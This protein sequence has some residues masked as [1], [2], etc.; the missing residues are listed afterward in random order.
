M[1]KGLID[2]IE[3]CFVHFHGFLF[4]KLV[5]SVDGRLGV[6]VCFITFVLSHQ[7]LSLCCSLVFGDDD[8]CLNLFIQH[9]GLL[10]ARLAF[11]NDLYLIGLDEMDIYL[12][13][14]GAVIEL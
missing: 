13:R 9:V 5:A 3:V 1:R 6:C 12:L 8:I 11:F 10:G 2:G 4:R 7:G 14:D